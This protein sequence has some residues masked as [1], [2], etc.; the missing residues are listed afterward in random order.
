MT[1]VRFRPVARVVD[2]QIDG[3]TLQLP[4]GE[5]LATALATAGILLLRQ[6][7]RTGAPRGAFCFMGACQ[8][9]ALIV[10]GELRQA[11]MTPVR[12]GLVVELRGAP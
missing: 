7:P 8:E 2:V 12:A 4:E 5:P 3:R 11:C 6:S 10:D 9:C 1:A